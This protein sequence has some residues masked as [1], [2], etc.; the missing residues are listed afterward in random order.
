MTTLSIT[1]ETLYRYP[2]SVEQAHHLSYLQPLSL[3]TQTVEAFALDIEPAPSHRVTETDVYGN[4]RCIFQLHAP[5]QMLRVCATSRVEVSAR[6]AQLDPAVSDAWEEVAHQLRYTAGMA[7]RRESEFVF[8]SPY[9]PIHSQLQHYALASFAPGRPLAEAAIDLMLRI[10]DDFVYESDSTD[11]STPVLKAFTTRRGVCQDFAHVLI[12]C[13]RALGLA[14]RYVS[15]YL[16]SSPP[17][18]QP[19]LVGADASHAWVSVYVPGLAANQGWL[20]LDPTNAMVPGDEHVLV[21][22]GRDYG[23]VTPLRGVIRGAGGHDLTVAVTVA[24]ED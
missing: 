24:P 7:F 23:D 6:Y 10:H 18:G 22:C 11:V 20:D 21:A 5:H 4:T 19:R 9:V 12:G 1:H 17:P 2:G 14:A 8:A 13:L 16:V 3:P 15:G